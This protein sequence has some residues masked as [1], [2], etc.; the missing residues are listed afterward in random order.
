MERMVTIGVE[1]IVANQS[2]DIT[3]RATPGFRVNPTLLPLHPVIAV[4]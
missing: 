4:S 3:H 1:R 2:R